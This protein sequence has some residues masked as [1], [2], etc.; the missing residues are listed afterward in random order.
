M[1]KAV[2][3]P[4][5]RVLL[6]TPES[7]SS[8]E[9]HAATESALR[10]GI[11]A[12]Q[13][14]DKR[15]SGRDVLHAAQNLRAL[16]RSFGALLF[17]NGRVDVASACG[18]DGVHLGVNEIPPEAARALLGKAARIGFS[19]HT[20]AECKS[21]KG[22]DWMTFSPVFPSPG[23]GQP[24]GVEGL[25]EAVHAAP[26]PV[27]ALGGITDENVAF[28]LQAGAQGVAVIRSVYDAVNVQD[29]A[30]RLVAAVQE[31]YGAKSSR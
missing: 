6:I 21:V 25:R 28:S 23:K 22:T 15:S 12:V 3:D 1:S 17:I 27:I 8:S 30:A 14:R 7:G 24:V 11:R 9:V 2:L 20:A 16:T 10:G 4:R 18:A 31:W 5:L 13:L 29:A 26:V 19:A